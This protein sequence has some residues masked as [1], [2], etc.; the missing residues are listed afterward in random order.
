[1]SQEL[2]HERF[3]FPVEDF[4]KQVKN[5]LGVQKVRIF[6]DNPNAQAMSRYVAGVL[7]VHL[8]TKQVVLS[9]RP[10]LTEGEAVAKIKS[11]VI[12][13]LCHGV[14]HETDH[15]DQVVSCTVGKMREHLRPEELAYPYIQD[16][17]SRLQ[18]ASKPIMATP[19]P[20]IR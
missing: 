15:T 9:Q 19:M 20:V 4:V 7:E 2:L 5:E 12:E 11:A 13:E 18:E 16:K 6:G 1:M 8:P 3:G 17:V 10:G 14:Y